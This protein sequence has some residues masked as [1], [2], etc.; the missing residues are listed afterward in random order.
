M[1]QHCPPA[2]IKQFHKKFSTLAKEYHRQSTVMFIPHY[3]DNAWHVHIGLASIRP[4]SDQQPLPAA[5]KARIW[6]SFA[7][8]KSGL[9][10]LIDN[11]ECC[12]TLADG[13]FQEATAADT[14][15]RWCLYCLRA[16][17]GFQPNEL[18]PIPVRPRKPYPATLGFR[19][20]RG[21]FVAATK[22]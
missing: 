4:L 7:A 9:N 11:T 12:S 10:V 15:K 18:P 22:T 1:R 6:T 19:I 13:R 21:R 20:K 14:Y 8:W 5:K 2:A 16:G 17:K 3:L